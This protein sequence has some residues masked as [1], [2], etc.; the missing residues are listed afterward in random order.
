MT[1]DT[2]ESGEREHGWLLEVE[3]HTKE[4][5][6]YKFVVW[7]E[8]LHIPSIKKFSDRVQRVNLETRDPRAEADIPECYLTPQSILLSRSETNLVSLGLP[9]PQ[10]TQAQAC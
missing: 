2:S 6:G 7:E 10:T 9:L 1:T 5:S 4:N 8:R 3:T